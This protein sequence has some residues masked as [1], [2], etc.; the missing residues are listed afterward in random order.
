MSLGP[1]PELETTL[2]Q[3]MLMGGWGSVHWSGMPQHCDALAVSCRF[4][5][6]Q[7]RAYSCHETRAR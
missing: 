7:E 1:S 6:P 2:Q 3:W 5:C 4:A